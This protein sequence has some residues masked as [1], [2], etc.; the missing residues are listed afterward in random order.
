MDFV[1]DADGDED[2]TGLEEVVVAEIQLE[3]GLLEFPFNIGAG[4]VGIEML[5]LH[6]GHEAEA[7]VELVGG[8]EDEA[9]DVELVRDIAGIEVSLSVRAEAEALIPTEILWV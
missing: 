6:F 8:E 3:V 5:Q 7:A 2:G 1:G 4:I 9:M